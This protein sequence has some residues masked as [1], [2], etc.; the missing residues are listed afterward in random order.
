MTLHCS[1]KIPELD[2]KKKHFQFW[3]IIL[4]HDHSNI[5][6]GKSKKKRAANHCVD[7]ILFLPQLSV[8]YLGDYSK[9]I[10]FSSKIK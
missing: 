6:K 10:G 2:T 4:N 7:G 3:P 1:I 9:C 8:Y 5:F